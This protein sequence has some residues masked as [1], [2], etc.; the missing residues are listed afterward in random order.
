MSV[1]TPRS[2]AHRYGPTRYANHYL[3]RCYDADGVLLYIGCTVEV[4]RRITAHRRGKGAK[5]ST[6]LAAC[7]AR[8]ETEGP[9]RGRDAG[10][11]AERDA[12]QAEQPIFNLQERKNEH[13][14][15]W[16][17]RAD[18]AEY[19]VEHGL[20]ALALE[21]ACLCWGD[22][23]EVNGV[24]PWCVA[25]MAELEAYVGERRAVA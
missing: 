8:Y 16:S 7:M 12:I 5:A 10:R 18:V 4:D 22:T 6:W 23:L 14:S 15:A 20:L 21:T 11:E 24:D 1:L 13:R 2:H 17:T 3:Y 19:L 25:H 9:Y